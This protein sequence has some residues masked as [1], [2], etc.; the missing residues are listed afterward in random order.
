MEERK[1]NNESLRAGLTGAAQS[2]NEIKISEALEKVA[3]E[4]G[5]ESVTAVALAY[6]MSKAP[7]VFP[8]VGGRK[9]EHLHDNIQALKIKLTQKQIE[10]LEAVVPFEAGFPN[11]FIG[12]DPHVSG[13]NGGFLMAT[14]AKVDFV[15]SGKPIGHQ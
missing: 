11:N 10:D 13:S 7:N 3:K 2:E 14:Q 12:E 8:I 1:K 9:V 4:H 6:V 15:Q 5:I